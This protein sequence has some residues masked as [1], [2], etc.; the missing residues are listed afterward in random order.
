MR[1]MIMNTKQN[2]KTNVTNIEEQKHFKNMF[3]WKIKKTKLF[4]NCGLIYCIV[5]RDIL[6]LCGKKAIHDALITKAVDFADRADTF[7]ASTLTNVNAKGSEIS[8]YCCLHC[9]SAFSKTLFITT[10]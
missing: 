8:R 5:C 10:F 6:L 4:D 3:Y 2:A 1:V 9:I 7:I